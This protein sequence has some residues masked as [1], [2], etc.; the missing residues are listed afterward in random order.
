MYDPE[1]HRNLF[2][3][4][5]LDFLAMVAGLLAINLNEKITGIIISMWVYT[6]KL[7]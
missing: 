3:F 7:I 6:L 5:E 1:A 4:P 2:K